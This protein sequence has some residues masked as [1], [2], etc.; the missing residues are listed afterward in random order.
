[1]ARSATILRKL[2]LREGSGLISNDERGF[3]GREPVA[4]ERGEFEDELGAGIL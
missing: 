3:L 2:T 1:M 4:I